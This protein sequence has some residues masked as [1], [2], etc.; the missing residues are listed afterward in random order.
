MVLGLCR[1]CLWLS[2][3]GCFYEQTIKLIVNIYIYIY[4]Y[5][6]RERERERGGEK[7]R[8]RERENM[9]LSNHPPWRGCYAR[10]ILFVVTR[11][12]IQSFPSSRLV[13]I[14]KQKNYPT[15]YP[16]PEREN[17]CI[18]AFP[19]KVIVKCKRKQYRRWFE[20]NRNAKCVSP[21]Y[22]PYPISFVNLNSPWSFYKKNF[23][24]YLRYQN[25]YF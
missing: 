18:H 3:Y 17:R 16:S 15:I 9:Y 7:E 22:I 4:T 23:L 25:N 8:E 6:E 24:P 1:F 13:T 12:W 19:K 14:P 2:R 21:I 10:S 20:N 5:W 11:I